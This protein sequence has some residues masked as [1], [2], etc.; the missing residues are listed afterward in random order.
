MSDDRAKE[1]R[2]HEQEVDVDLTLERDI[3]MVEQGVDTYLQYPNERVRRDL[4]IAL[5]KLDDQLD[6][7]D[8]YHARLR[9]PFGPESSVIGATTDSSVAEQLPATEFQ[10]Q[11]ALVKAAKNAVTRLTPDTLADLRSASEALAEWRSS[12]Q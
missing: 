1:E 5:E 10:A 4:L 9:L 11:V 6:Q 2:G 7:G 3:S 12:D 8:T